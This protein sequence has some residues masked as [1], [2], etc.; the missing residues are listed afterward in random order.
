VTLALQVLRGQ[1]APLA[2]KGLRATLALLVLKVLLVLA[3][4]LVALLAL[5]QPKLPPLTMT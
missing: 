3:F 2:H 4:L 5:F 1:L